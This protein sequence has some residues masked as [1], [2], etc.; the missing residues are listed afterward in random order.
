MGEREREQA[1]GG[2]QERPDL[3]E[4]GGPRH[5][6]GFRGRDW[7]PLPGDLG[8]ERRERRA[9]LHEDG[10]GDQEADGLAAGD[11]Q[12][13]HGAPGGGARCPRASRGAAEPFCPFS[14]PATLS[15]YP[16]KERTSVPTLA[17]AERGLSGWRGATPGGS[18]GACA[19]GGAP[20]AAWRL[21]PPC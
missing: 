3:E 5:G 2:E 8:E 7:D 20:R 4:G 19:W 21:P 11:E 12:A 17:P 1:A 14:H 6:Q 15:V 9:G 10:Q 16:L 18:S 13:Q